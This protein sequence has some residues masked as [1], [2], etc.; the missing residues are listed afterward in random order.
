[1]EYQTQIVSNAKA[2]ALAIQEQGFRIVS[3][4][5]DNHLCLVEVFSQGITGKQAEKALE[6]AL[7]T[8]NKNMIPFDTHP[9]LVTSGIRLGTPAVTTRNMKEPEMGQ[10]AEMMGKVLKNIDSDRVQSE[11]KEEVKTFTDR[12]P[13]YPKRLVPVS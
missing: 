10:I 7:I 5:T 1:M 11:V 3:D 2:L 9:P 8:V 4:G 12:F 6:Q 13:L